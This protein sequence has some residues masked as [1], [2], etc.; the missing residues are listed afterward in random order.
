MF[1][2]LAYPY[3]KFPRFMFSL[4]LMFLFSVFGQFYS[5][6]LVLDCISLSFFKGFINFLF[7]SLNHLYKIGF[8]VIFMCL[9]SVRLSS[10]SCS[11]SPGLWWYHIA[12]PV[13]DTFL[14]Q[15]S[16]HIVAPGVFWM[17]LI[18]A[19]LL[20]KAVK[21]L[22]LTKEV[23]IQLSWPLLAVLQAILTG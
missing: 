12:L 16:I 23:R 11:R 5:F 17:I 13:V 10:P 3:S 14:T 20:K 6:L 18:L 19:E 7:K 15:S 21:V 9:F 1:S 8:K 22:V 2:F 4:L